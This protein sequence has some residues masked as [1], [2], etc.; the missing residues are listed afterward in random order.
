MAISLEEHV[1]TLFQVQRKS[2][3]LKALNEI[4]KTVYESLKRKSKSLNGGQ[5]DLSDIQNCWQRFV[6]NIEKY[7]KKHESALKNDILLFLLKCVDIAFKEKIKNKK[8]E[9]SF[10]N[11]DDIE[12]H[13][14][15]EDEGIDLKRVLKKCIEKLTY[16]RRL[17]LELFYYEGLSYKEIAIE[18]SIS[19]NHARGYAFGAREKLRACAKQEMNE[20]D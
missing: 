4:Y 19:E 1:R 2:E 18:L 8:A 5:A 15:I 16:Q 14:I 10:E 3:R 13:N 6:R 20:H 9:Y 12:A 17:I 11:L 7:C